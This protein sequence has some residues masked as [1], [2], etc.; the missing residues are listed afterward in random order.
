MIPND[1]LA[2]CR[3]KII[4]FYEQR[5]HFKSEVEDWWCNA[6]KTRVEQD[7]ASNTQIMRLTD[8]VMPP[9]R[10]MVLISEMMY[11][12]RSCLDQL[13]W[14]AV[15][16]DGGTPTKQMQFPIFWTKKEFLGRKDRYCVRANKGA[17]WVP[18]ISPARLAALH[19]LQPWYSP[20]P[21]RLHPLWVLNT[22]CNIDKHRYVLSAVPRMGKGIIEV[23]Y[24][25]ASD[26]PSFIPTALKE[27]AVV[28]TGP[29]PG[30]NSQM[31]VK[32]ACTLLFDTGTESARGLN[33]MYALRDMGPWIETRVLS[34]DGFAMGLV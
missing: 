13:F 23:G 27:G 11:N 26:L 33:V 24:A 1:P 16:A 18:Q 15:I 6:Y 34:P 7:T 31:K 29:I 12:L 22:L 4:R 30:P 20:K 21:R 3:A 28:M 8:V 5:D 10:L 14:Q 2:G 32:F 9:E 17:P 19:R 25:R